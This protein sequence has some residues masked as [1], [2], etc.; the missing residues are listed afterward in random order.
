MGI[1]RFV[2]V[3]FISVITL[4]C[5]GQLTPNTLLRSFNAEVNSIE[6]DENRGLAYFAGEF[7]TYAG[8]RNGGEIFNENTMRPSYALPWV[9]YVHITVDDGEGGWIIAT[10]YFEGVDESSTQN[11]QFIQIHPDGSYTDLPYNIA[12]NQAGWEVDEMIRYGDYIIYGVGYDITIFNWHTGEVMMEASA[13]DWV[14]HLVV[15]DNMLYVTG[16]FTAME[17]EARNRLARFDLSTFQLTDWNPV[18][19]YFT[20]I[21]SQPEV[22][23]MVATANH[24]YFLLAKTVYSNGSSNSTTYYKI[25]KLNRTD[26]S[27]I[28]MIDFYTMNSAGYLTVWNDRILL[29]EYYTNS[30]MPY[31]TLIHSFAD[32]PLYD[33]TTHFYI[34][35]DGSVGYMN[36]VDDVLYMTGGFQEIAG[37][38]RR[39]LAALNPEDLNV[40]PLNLPYN[41]TTGSY[42][43]VVPGEGGYFINSDL[44]LLGGFEANY[45][46]TIDLN[47]GELIPNTLEFINPVSELALTSTGDT[48]FLAGNSPTVNVLGSPRM[49]AMNPVT[50]TVYD[51]VASTPSLTS[52]DIVD[53]HLFIQFN[54]TNASVNGQGR[55]RI[56]SFDLATLTLE[57]VF[58][59]INGE[60]TDFEVSGD[61]MLIVGSFSNVNSTSRSS[62]AMV[63]KNT[64][65]VH[66]WDAQLSTIFLAQYPTIGSGAK[67][68]KMHHGHVLLGGWFGPN[69]GEADN[70]ITAYF[71]AQDGTRFPGYNVPVQGNIVYV[72]N[73]K[74]RGDLL[75]I[76]GNF[77]N[78]SGPT[79]GAVTAIDLTNGTFV[80]QN[81][82]PPGGIIGAADL[83]I[84]GNQ[85]ISVGEYSSMNG[86][87]DI[88]YCTSWD[89]GCAAGGLSIPSAINHCDGY[90]LEIPSAWS[91]GLP[92]SYS[93]E[94]SSDNGQ[95]WMNLEGT[96]ALLHV[97]DAGTEYANAQIRVSGI[98]TCDTVMSNTTIVSI[99]PG[100]PI[101]AGISDATV[102]QGSVVAFT[103]PIPVEWSNGAITGLPLTLNGLGS[104]YAVATTDQGCYLPDTVN[105]VVLPNP[106]LNFTILDSLN[107]DGVEGAILLQASG[108]QTPYTYLF[109]GSIINAFVSNVMGNDYAVRDANYCTADV[110]VYLPHSSICYGCMDPEA[111]NYN[112]QSVFGGECEYFTTSCDYDLSGDGVINVADMN[113]LLTNFGCVGWDCEGDFDG[114]QIVGVTDI[115]FIIQYFNFFCE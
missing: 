72:R 28:E 75:Y 109:N 62:A 11:Y 6:V 54:S 73:W 113:E 106:T 27:F 4:S 84:Y 92:E 42:K 31:S 69:S 86:D 110:Y 67:L 83:E 10:H 79:T 44:G 112:E 111:S 89:M 12:T 16:Y 7:S 81:V 21:S 56:A 19:D 50:Q 52:I 96:G 88:R 68:V 101:G 38:V 40:L 49:F 85:L 32:T 30:G 105:Y 29:K 77:F 3:S 41:G 2:L 104:A 45:F 15:Y 65:A 14:R 26:N 100:L 20:N 102:C 17:G 97:Y 33:E 39:G 34:E 71:N 35:F 60:I 22:T 47:T 78:T 1:F 43:Q 57:P 70:S 99:L 87:S 8:S 93:W 108:G 13:S 66:P 9:P 90:D 74:Q 103:S 59:N 24:F 37:H 107:C 18:V 53:G 23:E 98:S 36:L 94:W 114:D 5:F 58:F 63:N 91:N 25:V 64:F 61:T 46:A 115:Y 55:S 48:L 95:T 80:N 76:A 82:R 51:W